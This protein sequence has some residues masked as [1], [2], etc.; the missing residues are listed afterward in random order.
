MLKVSAK[1]VLGAVSCRG[2]RAGGGWFRTNRT[3]LG[4]NWSGWFF[5]GK[6]EGNVGAS[7][8][9]KKKIKFHQSYFIYFFG[10]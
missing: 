4:Q 3:A 7:F 2:E 5:I 8:S 10:L 1:Q 6:V 9:I